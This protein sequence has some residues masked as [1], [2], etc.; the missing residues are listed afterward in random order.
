[1]SEGKYKAAEILAKLRGMLVEKQEVTHTLDA[2]SLFRIR[3]EAERRLSESNRET[4][5]DRGVF[6][7]QHLL[8]EKIRE[9]KGQK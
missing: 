8:P 3:A 9:D 2:D 1:M 7:E 4:D 5:R 6:Q